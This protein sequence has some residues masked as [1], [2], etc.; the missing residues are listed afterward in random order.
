[1]E[2]SK[3]KPEVT[4]VVNTY[5]QETLIKDCLDGIISQDY[6]ENIKILIIDDASNDDTVKICGWYQERHPGKIDLICLPENE[7]SQGLFVGLDAH[8]KIRTKYIAW[9]DGDDYWI[10][11]TKIKQ[12]VNLMEQDASIGIV[13][14]NYSF[15]HQLEN[16]KRYEERKPSDVK[17]SMQVSEGMDLIFG[18]YIKHST[19]MILTE[20]IDFDFVAA[21]VGIKARDWLI[22]V[23]AT[24]SRKVKFNNLTTSVI[25]ITQSGIWNG[26]SPE[27]NLEQKSRVRWYC[28]S[29][30]PDCTLRE[31]F[32]REIALDWFRNF[33]SGLL[34]YKLIR[35]VMILFRKIKRRLT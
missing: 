10:D 21:P 3:S 29:Q 25:R 35:P 15:I 20:A 19:A 2:N 32:R 4:V 11:I 31:T 7:Y 24:R 26:S 5:N 18:N 34:V 33:I 6:F 12:Q 14:T 13:H 28:A 23:S 27:I 22:Y 1:M 30:L 9:C 17:K 16:E 8:K